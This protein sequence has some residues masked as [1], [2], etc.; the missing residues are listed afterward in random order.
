MS[1]SKVRIWSVAL[2]VLRITT[3]SPVQAPGASLKQLEVPP[4]YRNK[5]GRG[6]V[7][8]LRVVE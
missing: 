1:R 8:A 5:L 6:R 4:Q 3:K 7:N 2:V